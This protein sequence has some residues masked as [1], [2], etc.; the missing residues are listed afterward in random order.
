MQSIDESRLE[1]DLEYRFN[2][3]A[4]FI[5]F[6]PEDAA[7]IQASAPHLGPRI[8]EL[9][10]NTYDHLLAYDAT[11]RHFLLRQDG[12]AG[13]PP[14]DMSELDASHPQVRFRME[15]LS[16][17]FTHLFGRSYD[18]KMILYLDTVGKMHTARAGNASI[19]V[20]LV[21]MNALLGLLSDVLTASIA[22]WQLS[23]EQKMATTR[24]FQ[25]LM[26]IQNDL[27]NRHYCCPG[28]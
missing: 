28:E 21:Q 6:G 8:P 10:Q 3:L 16:R 18:A 22:E 23:P 2:Y 24:A 26:W 19:V 12:F 14:E 4:E 13:Q 7:L 9:V 11:A 27:I 5:G 17:Y 15:H 25:K 20:P 1:S